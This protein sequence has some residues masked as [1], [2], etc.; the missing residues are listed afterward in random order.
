MDHSINKKSNW[1]KGLTLAIVAF[2]VAML[3]MVYIA[4]RQSNEM[5][6]DNYY[7]R[8]LKYQNIID[9]KDELINYRDFE[10]ISSDEQSVHF[11]LPSAVS[12]KIESGYVQFIKLDNQS[13]DKKFPITQ[14]NASSLSILKSELSRGEYRVKLTWNNA[15][16]DYFYEKDYMVK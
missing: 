1:G 16:K 13:L 11:H 6:E 15:G 7:E 14:S 4:F 3:G 12:D 8:E 2:M 9:A 5:I 10:Y